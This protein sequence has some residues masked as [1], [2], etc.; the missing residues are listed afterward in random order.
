MAK[1]PLSIVLYG[2]GELRG[3]ECASQEEWLELIKNAGLPVP[4]KTL[5]VR[6]TTKAQLLNAVEELD[7]ARKKFPTPRMA[8]W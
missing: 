8:R 7:L 2:P 5:V 3:V 1:R 6:K 4:E